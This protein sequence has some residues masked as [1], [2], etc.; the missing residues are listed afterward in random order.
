MNEHLG[1]RIKNLRTEKGL[2]QSFVARKLGYKYSSTLS[3]IESGKKGINAEKIPLVAK[4]LDV[5]I[6]ELFFEEKVHK[7][8]TSSNSA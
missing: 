5:D 6:N 2:T 3:E 1:V 7:M 8:R 4:I